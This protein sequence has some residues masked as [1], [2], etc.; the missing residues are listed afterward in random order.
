[1]RRAGRA[2]RDQGFIPG[3]QLTVA[4]EPGGESPL[5][6]ELG[7]G[8]TCQPAWHGTER[9]RDLSQNFLS[10]HLIFLL[11]RTNPKT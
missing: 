10:C 3:R 11:V 5:M 4:E 6:L 9:L 2:N 8:E 1:M 7:V